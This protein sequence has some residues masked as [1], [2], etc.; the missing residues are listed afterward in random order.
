MIFCKSRRFIFLRVPKTA[1]TSLSLQILKN[2]ELLPGDFSTGFAGKP[3]LGFR[4]VVSRHP[5]MPLW[6]DEHAILPTILRMGIVKEE[7]LESYSIYGVLRNPVDRFISMCVHVLGDFYK[8]DIA[9]MEKDQ[10]AIVGLDLLKKLKEPY[11]FT[12]PGVALQF[13][14]HSQSNWLLLNDKPI[15]NIV[16]YPQFDELL[17]PLTHSSKLEHKEKIGI[18]PIPSEVSSLIVR[19]IRDWYPQDFEL[20]EGFSQPLQP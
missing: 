11:M 16:L 8:M 6:K 13:P 14:M 5:T 10:I 17:V 3:P 2:I 4:D 19:R 1:S 18:K 7:E 9:R 15:N 20:W 12:V